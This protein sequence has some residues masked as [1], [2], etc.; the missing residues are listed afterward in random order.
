MAKLQI[1]LDEAQCKIILHALASER[2][3]AGGTAVKAGIE[4]VRAYLA[5]RVVK[6]WGRG[7]DSAMQDSTARK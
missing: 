7:D 5:W 3:R 6:L 2:D 1:R 4:R